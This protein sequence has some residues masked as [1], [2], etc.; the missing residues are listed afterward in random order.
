MNS[1][2]SEFIADPEL[3]YRIRKESQLH[4]FGANDVLFRQGDSPRFLYLL[5]SGEA[6]LTTEVLNKT[7]PIVRAGAGSLIGLRAIIARKPYTMTARA[8][9]DLYAFCL[10]AGPFEELLESEPGLSRSVLRILAAD[11]RSER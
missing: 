9:G 1:N 11:I 4:F 6:V 10:E 5:Q 3:A 8:N 2:P 7:I